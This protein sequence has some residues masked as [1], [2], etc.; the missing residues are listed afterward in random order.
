MLI[1]GCREVSLR[2]HHR[3]DRQAALNKMSELLKSIDGWEGKD[4]NQS[5]NKFIMGVYIGSN[6]I[7]NLVK[8]HKNRQIKL[9]IN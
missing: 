4:T 9:Y 1:L 7:S 8:T 3:G 6:H 5:C 2:F